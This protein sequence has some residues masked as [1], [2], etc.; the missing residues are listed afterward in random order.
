MAAYEV[1]NTT[2]NGLFDP[3]EMMHSILDEG[4]N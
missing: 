4:F 2:G 3:N 1:N